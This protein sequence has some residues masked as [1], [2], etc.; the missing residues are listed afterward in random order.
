MGKYSLSVKEIK[1]IAVDL[2]EGKIF[3]N[4]HLQNQNDIPTVFM[5]MIFLSNEQRQQLIDDEAIF[6]FEYYDKANQ[7]SVNGYP[8]FFSCRFMTKE[9][10]YQMWVEYQKYVEMREEF[11]EDFEPNIPTN[12]GELVL[13][14]E[15]INKYKLNS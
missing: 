7:L 6:I 11:L 15:D 4:L 8:T 12:F 2:A 5:V 14:E 10:F 1:Q 3:S 13:T 9:D